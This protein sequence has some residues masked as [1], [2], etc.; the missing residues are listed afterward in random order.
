MLIGLTGGI[1][2]GKST[3]SRMIKSLGLPVIDA[4]VIAR[5]VVEPG[6]EC[7]KQIVSHFGSEVLDSD[8]VLKRKKLGEIIFSDQ[9]KRDVLNQ[10]VHP[11]VRK[12]MNEQKEHYLASGF[13][14]IV[15]DIPLLYESNLFHLVEKVL[16]VYVDEDTQLFRL[17]ERDNINKEAALSRILSQQALI[18]KKARADAIIDNGGSILETENQLHAILKNWDIP[19]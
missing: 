7:L 2:S 14:T 13:Q 18:D 15:Y 9:K 5:E 3:V 10:I 16:L 17:M 8:G 6:T 1:A 11:A 4:D 12:R 19:V